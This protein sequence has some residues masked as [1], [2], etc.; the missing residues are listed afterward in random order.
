MKSDRTLLKWYRKVNRRFFDGQLPENVCVRWANDAEEKEVK[1]EEKYF[2]WAT[3][4]ENEGHNPRYHSYT[5]VLSRSHHGGAKQC[6][7]HSAIL[8]TLAHE[9][10]HLATQL[11]DDHGD[12][13]EK[14]RQYIADRGIFRKHALVKNL[15]IF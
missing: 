15:T 7:P 1:W 5:I 13:F 12:A 9:M 2:G 10:V 6:R 3:Q 11:R 8:S 4:N 14:W